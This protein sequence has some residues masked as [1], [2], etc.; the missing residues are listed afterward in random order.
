[1]FKMKEEMHCNEMLRDAFVG[2]SSSILSSFDFLMRTQTMEEAER[3]L[4]TESSASSMPYD[5][6]T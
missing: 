3:F 1:M 5:T 4:A 2:S 6:T